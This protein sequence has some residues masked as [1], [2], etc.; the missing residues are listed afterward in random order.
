[1]ESA[2]LQALV[3]QTIDDIYLVD[4][5]DR[6]AEDSYSAWQLIL[7]L[8][9]GNQLLVV[10]DAYDGDHIDLRLIPRSQLESILS[11][12]TVPTLW[13]PFK[14]GPS[15]RSVFYSRDKSRSC[16]MRRTSPNSVLM[17]N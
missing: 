3:Q 1:M 12:A 10:E 16:C 5:E 11:Q 14:T 9:D 13:K 7:V 2:F 8:Q 17:E 15:M 4:F 6:L